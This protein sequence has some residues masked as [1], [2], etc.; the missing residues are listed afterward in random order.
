MF[1]CLVKKNSIIFF[2]LFQRYNYNYAKPPV[3]HYN[4]NPQAGHAAVTPIYRADRCHATSRFRFPFSNFRFSFPTPSLSPGIGH[5][6]T[7]VDRFPSPSSGTYWTRY[8]LATVQ[9]LR[10]SDL[11]F[12][13]FVLYTNFHFPISIFRPSGIYRLNADLAAFTS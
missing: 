6:N 7:M 3:H 1:H 13:I 4:T 5:S 2:V 11:N 9:P 10:V 12:P 8:L